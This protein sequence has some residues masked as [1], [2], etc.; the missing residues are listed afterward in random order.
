M[1]IL[2]LDPGSA[3]VGYALLEKK[4]K[5]LFSLK[6]GCITTDSR[7]PASRR[8]VQIERELAKIVKKYHPQE[9]VVEKLFFFKNLKT[10]IAV[11]QARGVILA[12]LERVGLKTFEYTPLQ[13]KL[14]VTGYGKA[15]KIQVQ[16]MVKNILN[17]REIP[18]PDDAA[19]ALAIAI[20]HSYQL[21]IKSAKLKV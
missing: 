9:A 21:K 11:S 8:L 1:S 10:A 13:V 4:D 16:R 7:Q 2:G 6:Y 15:P 20:C 5:K 18:R 3:I 17:L 14:S 12:T 19:D